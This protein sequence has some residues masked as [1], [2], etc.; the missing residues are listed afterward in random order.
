MPTLLL[1]GTLTAVSPI[2]II[3]P[4][5]EDKRTPA[6]APRKRMLRDGLMV[7]T[8]YVP[9]SSLR[10]RLRHLLT[11]E[12]MRMQNAVEQRGFTASSNHLSSR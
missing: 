3:L 2:A 9:P 6:G 4:G 5:S 12:L 10:G 1:D 7:E 11:T 8:V